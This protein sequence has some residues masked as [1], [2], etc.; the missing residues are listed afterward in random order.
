APM[1][2]EANEK[3]LTLA[4][5]DWPFL[6]ELNEDNRWEWYILSLILTMKRVTTH[7]F[8]WR[9]SPVATIGNHAM[10]IRAT[11][12]VCSCRRGKYSLAC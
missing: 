7:R 12:A 1:I 11:G 2:R 10:V 8:G 4:E 3:Q 5:F 6:S 9:S